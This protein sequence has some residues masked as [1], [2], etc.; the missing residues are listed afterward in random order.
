M[1]PIS[2]SEL[3]L[4]ERR[5]MPCMLSLSVKYVDINEPVKASDAGMAMIGVLVTD[6]ILAIKRMQ[7]N[8]KVRTLSKNRAGF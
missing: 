3:Q 6:A 2:I 1:H 5:I 7:N 8:I 4:S